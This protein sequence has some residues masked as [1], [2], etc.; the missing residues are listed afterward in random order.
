MPEYFVIS[1]LHLGDG[2]PRDAFSSKVRLAM[3]NAFL[4]YVAG[5]QGMLVVAGDLL[6]LWACRL[7]EVLV[8]HRDLL[9]RMSRLGPYYVLGN[10]DDHLQRIGGA[11]LAYVNP[12]FGSLRDRLTLQFPNGR[13]VLIMHGHQ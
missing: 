12:V 9:M 3:L 13:S 5:E 4:D 8:A 6:E 11:A 2:T 10:H 1:D 7:G